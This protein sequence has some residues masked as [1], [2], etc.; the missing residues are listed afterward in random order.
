MLTAM[1]DT[2]RPSPPETW[3]GTFIAK[4]PDGSTSDF[5]LMG[6]KLSP[7]DRVPGKNYELERWEIAEQPREDGTWTVVGILRE[8][9]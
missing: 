3:D 5:D 1:T 9:E 4:Y 8:T 6:F 2:S 7:G